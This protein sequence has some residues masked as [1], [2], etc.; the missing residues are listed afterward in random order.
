MLFN[1]LKV[2]LRSLAANKTF[3]IINISG[4][5][6]GIT[7]SVLILMVVA[8]EFSF[9]RFH[10]NGERIVRA[11]KQFSR[12]GRHS[13][14]ANPQ[15]GPSMMET[16]PRVI[17]YVRMYD[18]GRKI[19]SSDV[20]HTFFQE[21]FL[22]ADSS[23]FGMLSFPLVQGERKSLARSAT[24]IITEEMAQK[25]FGTTDVLGRMLTFDKKYQL[26]IVG[27]AKNA[28]LNS[29]IQFNIV[30]SFST[31]MIMPAERDIVMNNS[32]GFPT[33]LLLRSRNDLE[34]VSTSIA[35]TNYTNASVIY[36]LAPLFENH[37]NLNF[38]ATATTKY[39]YTFLSVSFLILLLALINYMNLTTA[40]SMTRAKEIG[41]RKV[42]GARRGA[43]SLQFYF[44]SAITTFVSFLIALV[45][46]EG[47][48][49][50]L[51]NVT[52][53]QFDSEFLRSPYLYGSIIFLILFCIIVAGSYPAIVLPRFRAADVLKGQFSFSA[54]GSWF[55]KTL[56]VFQ[57]SVS[58]CLAIC[59]VVMDSQVSFM[60]SLNTKIQR[61]Q[62]LVLP[63]ELLQPTQRNVFKTKLQAVSGIVG[64]ASASVPL[65]KNQMS[66][67][68]MVTSPVNNEKIGAKWI[69]VD[70]DFISVMR[71][72]YSATVDL[73]TN[74][75]YHILNQTA[76]AAFGITK[77]DP[78]YALTMGGDHV[79]AVSGGIKGVVQ[80][81]NYESLRNP[82]QPLIISVL[83]DTS[84]YL[85]DNPTMYIN[86]EKGAKVGPV[87]ESVKTI[88]NEVSDGSPFT[89]FFLDD[90][91]NGQ[92][93]SES[94][95]NGI[96]RM[97]TSVAIVIACLGLFGLITF[98]SERRKKELSIRKLLGASLMSITILISADLVILLLISV[99]VATPIAI[100]VMRDWLSGF[101]Y[102]TGISPFNII[103]PICA[104]LA[105]SLLVMWIQ[106]I[107]TALENPVKNLKSE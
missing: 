83:P 36:S 93:I 101:F 53:I 71:V 4:L 26:E 41:I 33:Y 15:F 68:S 82:I 48:R 73:P 6:I 50:L 104:V 14:Y 2:A 103:V 9:D 25:Y 13:L 12:D 54:K 47:C 61:D 56:M 74:G 79:P 23:F 24:A 27:I 102:Q 62:V 85:G 96:F 67:I 70:K 32:S 37:F 89:W 91:F 42:V 86:I 107:R 38:G 29:S 95:L 3:S 77:T 28:P 81:F 35:K 87:I 49:P 99:C 45:I 84:S 80:D 72:K 21:G 97:F 92:Q 51:A 106:G 88:Y 22:F 59:A 65:Y 34:A 18:G 100:Y 39:A 58:A 40:R 98:S 57:F 63:I 31:L 1:Y 17:N 5:A 60:S 90:A 11:E 75:T 52:G 43:L 30:A 66:G 20:D 46:I 94:R 44:E 7:A 76:A 55:R 105:I 69:I 10:V 78:E 8:H 16:D 19:V 64:V